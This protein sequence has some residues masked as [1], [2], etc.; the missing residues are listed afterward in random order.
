AWLASKIAPGS[1]KVDSRPRVARGPTPSVS[2]SRSQARC[3]TSSIIRDAAQRAIG[4][5]EGPVRS[6][7]PLTLTCDSHGRSAFAGGGAVDVL[8]GQGETIAHLDRAD[9]RQHQS[10]GNAVIHTKHEHLADPLVRQ[11][12][13]LA[14][15]RRGGAHGLARA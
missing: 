6:F 11:L 10:V 15:P 2:E 8:V 5:G 4:R 13:I 1:P 9:G 12:D 14:A 3:S 7:L